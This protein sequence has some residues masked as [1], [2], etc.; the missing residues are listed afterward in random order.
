MRKR[1]L[2]HAYSISLAGIFV[3]ITLH[4]TY[5]DLGLSDG[6]FGRVPVRDPVVALNDY[7]YVMFGVF[8]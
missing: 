5:L 7:A 3:D 6:T 1:R 2:V 8:I 4:H